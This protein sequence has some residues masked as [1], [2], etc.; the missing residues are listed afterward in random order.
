MKLLKLRFFYFVCLLSTLTAWAQDINVSGTVTDENGLPVPGASVYVKDA[1]TGTMTDIDGKYQI[2][3]PSAGTLVFTYVGYADQQLAV[4]GQ[5][6]I[7]VQIAP[8]T[9]AI[10]EVVVVGY[11]TQKKSVTTGAISSVRAEQLENMPITRVEQSLQGRVSGVTIFQNAGQ[12]GS[13]ST[14]RVRGITSFNGAANNPL[15]VVDGIIVDNA[16]IG[17]INQADIESIEVLKDA[18]SAAIY[19]TRAASGVIL[20]TTKKGKAGKFSVSYNGF[21]GSSKAARKIDLLNAQQYATLRNEQYANGYSTG[22]FALPYPNA[23][24]LGTGTN[25]QNEIFNDNA[26]RSQHEFSISGGT[27]KSRFYM[28][29]GYVDQEGIVTSEISKYLRK[30]I[31]L[32]SDHQVTKWLKIGQTLGYSREKTVGLG[33]TNGEYG[34][35]LASAINLDPTTPAIV[36]DLSSVPNPGDYAQQFAVKDANGNYYGISN[37][38]QQEMTNPLAYIQ[39]RLGNYDWA[40]NFVGN[41]FIEI[42]PIE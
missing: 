20:V 38:V 6:V 37:A 16:G 42:M 23:A 3:T 14:V 19:G 11:G 8:T 33:N 18:A 12:P 13:G 36:T 21:A 10:E 39:T 35:P 5:T 28:S 24:A 25:W 17:V 34:G 40:D 7:N 4:N 32:N 15:Y 41:A 31:R 29:F 27:E 1:T 30:N 26:Q 22:T 2:S 9:E